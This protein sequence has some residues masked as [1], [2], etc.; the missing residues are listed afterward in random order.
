[1]LIFI[2]PT[3]PHIQTAECN[4]R[5]IHFMRSFVFVLVFHFFFFFFIVQSENFNNLNSLLDRTD[6]NAA[7]LCVCL[8]I[9][10]VTAG[11]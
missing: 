11:N 2:T 9:R 6:T 1:M 5:K 4:F 3:Y 7:V 8:T 10:D